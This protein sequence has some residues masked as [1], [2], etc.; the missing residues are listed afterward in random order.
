M[1]QGTP[2]RNARL[3]A[4]AR[5]RSEGKTIAQANVEAGWSHDSG[6]AGRMSRNPEVLRRIA[7]LQ[8]PAIQKTIIT[9]EQLFQTFVDQGTFDPAIFDEVQ[10][11]ADLRH[12]VDEPTRRLLVK[13]WKYDRQGRFLLELVDKEKAL[14]RIARHLS[15][16][17]DTLKVDVSDFDKML[18]EAEKASDEAER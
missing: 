2:L 12:R 18:E 16:Y 8:Q 10:S 11:L 4:F 9:I 17:N 14:D 7:E 1:E 3:E 13:G 15:F 5:A 6:Y